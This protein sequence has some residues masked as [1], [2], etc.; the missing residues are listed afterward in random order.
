MR[1]QLLLLFSLFVITTNAAVIH[2]G[3]LWS[4]CNNGVVIVHSELLIA[5][6]PQ[7]TDSIRFDFGDGVEQFASLVDFTSCDTGNGTCI[8]RH[9]VVH[10]F[11]P[12]T[13]L[14]TIQTDSRLGGIA[15]MSNSGVSTFMLQASIVVDPNIGANEAPRSLL[16][17]FESELSSLQNNTIALNVTDADGDSIVWQMQLCLNATNYVYPDVV[18]GG[19]FLFDQAQQNYSWAPQT[20]GAYSVSFFFSEFR[21]VGPGNW[22]LI[23][24]SSQE[25]LL[26]VND[27]VNVEE[28]TTTSFLQ[29][30]PNPATNE[31]R[32][33]T[34][35]ANESTLEITDATGRVVLTK[36]LD[37]S[38]REHTVNIS[39]LTF[40]IYFVRVGEKVERVVVE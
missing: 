21:Q 19:T 13:Y 32:F 14:A 39:A 38:S 6:L 17:E 31:I 8:V 34:T 40:G 23:G 25:I 10:T 16:P 35:N 18:G 29:L 30:Y 24:Y 15:N 4:N 5:G 28:N 37:P 36:S 3:R 33:S 27:V 12:G 1:N 2:G 26:D 11:S 7:A 20:S 9:D 22:V